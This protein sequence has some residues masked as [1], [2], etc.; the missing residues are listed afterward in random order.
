MCE[1]FY[2][3]C[4][5]FPWKSLPSRNSSS[6]FAPCVLVVVGFTSPGRLP[7]VS[8]ARSSLL[9]AVKFRMKISLSW[10][11][12]SSQGKPPGVW[13]LCF[14]QNISALLQA[15]RWFWSFSGLA[16]RRGVLFCLALSLMPRTR[17]WRRL[18]SFLL[19]S[20]PYPMTT[21]F[22]DFSLRTVLLEVEQLSFA[23]C[24][25]SRLSFFSVHLDHVP[26]PCSSHDH[27]LGCV[28]TQEDTANVLYF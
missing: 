28:G 7:S 18:L 9:M 23:L 6:L 24:L 1:G 19:S 5:A 15:S 13:M 26:L 8:L 3:C 22:T 16:C 4:L 20:C 25:F 27:S 11:R 21:W 10:E 14:R 17:V 12:E 2:C